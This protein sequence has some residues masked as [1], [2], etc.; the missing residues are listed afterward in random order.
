[1]KK[2]KMMR[3]LTI[4][5]LTI[6]S[7]N[8]LCGS[9]WIDK[10]VVYTDRGVIVRDPEY[11]QPVFIFSDHDI[12]Q[13]TNMAMAEARG[14]GIKGK[15]LVMRVAINRW[16][17]GHYGEAL[18]DVIKPGQ[19]TLRSSVPPD[20]E[21]RIALTWIMYGWDESEGALYFCA[22][23]YNGPIPLFQYGGHYFS[24]KEFK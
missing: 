22:D 2:T 17:S 1:M 21:C 23:G 16:I 10:P 6:F 3:I 11:V 4:L 20:D 24:K 12:E 18:C 13:L 5:M 8:I 7:I 14:E 19:F 15:A 9:K